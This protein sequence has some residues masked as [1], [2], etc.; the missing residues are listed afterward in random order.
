MRIIA[1]A[2]QKGGTGKT[3]TAATLGAL[4]A[5]EGLRVLLVDIDP[6]ASLTLATVGN[7]EGQS[8]AE[9]IGGSAA[10]ALRLV[11][12]VKEIRPGLSL[13]PADIAL[14]SCE[15]S[16]VA[17]LAREMILSRALASV[18]P[19]YDIALVDCP[20]SLGLLTVNALTA[21]DGIIAPVLPAVSDLRGLRLF[22]DSI[23][24]VKDINTRLELLGVIV[25]QFDPR[26]NS[27]NQVIGMLENAGLP[28]LATVAR[29]VRVAEAAGARALL[30]D[31][32]PSGKPLSGYKELTGKVLEWLNNH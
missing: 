21:A 18:A 1:I 13:A 5:A 6:Q 16:I 31:Y 4:L 29:S 12:V 3:A 26:I 23:E 2:N 10:G 7:S 24:R 22:L 8:L 9:V 14:A 15:L 28:L 30:T 19:G 20:P 25:C 17:R 32:D 27:H 11:E